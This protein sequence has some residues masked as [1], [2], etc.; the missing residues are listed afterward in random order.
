MDITTITDFLS[1]KNGI[2]AGLTALISLLLLVFK[3]FQT[4]KK[5]KLLSRADLVVSPLDTD[6]RARALPGYPVLTPHDGRGRIFTYGVKLKINLA[7]NRK[8]DDEITVHAVTVQVDAY[9]PSERPEFNYSAD[10]D[11][12]IGRRIAPTRVFNVQLSGQKVLESTWIDANSEP[13][14]SKSANILDVPAPFSLRLQKEEPGELLEITVAACEFGLYT[15]RLIF[16][17]FIAGKDRER[18]SEPIQFYFFE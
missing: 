11:S 1:S 9:D 13:Q 8:S 10:F 17:Y 12:L 5:A 2:I 14:Q 6:E 7:H 3:L 18:V 16:H 4:V 15:F